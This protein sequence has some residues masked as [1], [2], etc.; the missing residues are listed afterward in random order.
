MCKQYQRSSSGRA[1]DGSLAKGISSGISQLV[2]WNGW[3]GDD[4]V[5]ELK[6]SGSSYGA[7]S[8]DQRA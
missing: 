6:A 8:R 5:G 2:T 1:L 4:G 7:S 3:S